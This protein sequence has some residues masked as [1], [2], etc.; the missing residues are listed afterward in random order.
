MNFKTKDAPKKIMQLFT[1]LIAKGVE[2][3]IRNDGTE[4][5]SVCNMSTGATVIYYNG[6]DLWDGNNFIKPNATKE[7]AAL[8]LERCNEKWN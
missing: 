1:D 7:E 5:P 8:W 2:S 4:P 6:Y 3:K